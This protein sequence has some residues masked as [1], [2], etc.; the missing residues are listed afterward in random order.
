MTINSLLVS[1]TY[2]TD[3]TLFAGTVESGILWSRDGGQ[4]WEQPGEGD[5]PAVWSLAEAMSEEGRLL[6]TGTQD[7]G[8]LSFVDDWQ[9]INARQLQ[10]G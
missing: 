4:R 2:N 9:G 7:Q 8:L 10:D 3:H 1:S 6:L 5:M